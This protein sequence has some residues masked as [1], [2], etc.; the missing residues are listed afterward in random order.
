MRY[1]GYEAERYQVTTEDGYIL[2]LYRC[3]SK[4]PFAGIK[5]VVVLL[6]GIL[7][8]SDDFAFLPNSLGNLKCML[9]KKRWKL[10]LFLIFI[11]YGVAYV[12]ADAG[13]DVWIINSRG[14]YYSRKHSNLNPDVP[15]SGFWNFTPETIGLNDLPPSFVFILKV[16][17]Q[18]ALYVIAHSMG[19]TEMLTLLGWLLLS[20]FVR[21]IEKFSDLI[22]ISFYV[23]LCFTSRETGME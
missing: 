7:C 16:T 22:G 9:R 23:H 2:T 1:Y 8:T 10:I 4:K 5:R 19:T 11:L 15:S 12:M 17:G 18:P 6:P 14:N 20:I 21:I 13:Y 3:N